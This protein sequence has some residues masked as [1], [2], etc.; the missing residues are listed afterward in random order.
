MP[1]FFAMNAVPTHN[2]RF[3]IMTVSRQQY[4]H[5][6]GVSEVGTV[7]AWRHNSM[8][9]GSASRLGGVPPAHPRVGLEAEENIFEPGRH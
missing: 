5:G 2:Y 1:I 4:K 9:N 6:R 3:D 7:R 8:Q